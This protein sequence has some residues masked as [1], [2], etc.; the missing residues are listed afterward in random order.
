MPPSDLLGRG[1]GGRQRPAARAGDL[2]RLPASGLVVDQLG[3]AEI[4]QLHAAFARDKDVRRFEIPVNDEV[5]VRVRHRRQHIE[6]EPH[7]RIDREPIR[8]AISI[9]RLAINVLEHEIR[10][11]DLGDAGIDEMR[12]VRMRELGENTG[13][14]CEPSL[15]GMADECG[16]EKLDRRSSL[17]TP[18]APLGEPHAAHAAMTDR[19][20]QP[21]VTDPSGH[22]TGWRLLGPIVEEA[23]AHHVRIA[24]EQQL[25]ARR[26]GRT[27]A[28]QLLE[29]GRAVALR[30]LQRDIEIGTGEAPGFGI[31]R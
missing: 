2:G 12:D 1:I 19:C 17:E 15:H 14:T 16:V 18:I 31:Q 10:L 23:L 30:E 5:G 27:I 4:E 6:K 13:L 29:P 24:V 8:V 20:H 9:D 11:T 25:D 3:D 28:L 7:T 26:D 22:D 21:V